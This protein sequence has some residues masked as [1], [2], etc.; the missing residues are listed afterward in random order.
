MIEIV[1]STKNIF[2][3]NPK[4]DDANTDGINTNIIK[5]FTTPPVK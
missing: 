3:L 5:G 4:L 2:V 1:I